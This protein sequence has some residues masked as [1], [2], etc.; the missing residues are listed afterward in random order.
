MRVLSFL[1][2]QI[3]LFT[4][5][6]GQ[7]PV[8]QAKKEALQDTLVKDPVLFL[9][10]ASR[11]LKWEEPAVPVHI[12]GPIYFVGTKGLASYLIKTSKGLIVLYTGMP[13][14]GPM[15]EKSISALGF[16]PKDIKLLLTGHAHS[17]H[18]GGHKY[19]QEIS[20]AKVV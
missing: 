10:L 20:G 6:S 15:I 8:D 9:K 11:Q 2:L 4:N 16:N 18:I 5:L 14:S 19:L 3:L 12:A 1:L 7:A 17:D 13:S